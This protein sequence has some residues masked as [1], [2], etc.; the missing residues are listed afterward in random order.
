MM[1]KLQAKVD[2]PMDTIN[3]QRRIATEKIAGVL[4]G[5]LRRFLFALICVTVAWF[6]INQTETRITKEKTQEAHMLFES[7]LNV[8][9]SEILLLQNQCMA[10]KH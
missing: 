7:R 8:A 2:G 1:S 5:I 3:N 9:N 4:H 10:P 6:A